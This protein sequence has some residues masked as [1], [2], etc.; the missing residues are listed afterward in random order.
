MDARNVGFDK[1]DR[2]AFLIA[3]QKER[4]QLDG[5][6]KFVLATGPCHIQY[7]FSLP[8]KASTFGF[9]L[10]DTKTTFYLQNTKGGSILV[11]SRVCLFYELFDNETYTT[12]L[13][14]GVEYTLELN[15]VVEEA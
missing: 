11:L 13:P 4:M 15:K 8:S 7:Y 2:E 3:H 5:P 6:C 1:D 10:L 9:F 14:N 12:T